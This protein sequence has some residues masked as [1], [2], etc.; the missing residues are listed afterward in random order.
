M[1][2]SIA[3][4][5]TWK[6]NRDRAKRK[7]HDKAQRETHDRQETQENRGAK[8]NQ[9]ASKAEKKFQGQYRDLDIAIIHSTVQSIEVL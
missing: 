3:M 8:D 9:E 5:C 2:K 4:Y 7:R 1:Y 6:A